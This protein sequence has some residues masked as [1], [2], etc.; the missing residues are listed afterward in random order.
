MYGYHL[1]I[2][3]M[4]GLL[5]RQSSITKHYHGNTKARRQSI[6]VEKPTGI[7]RVRKCRS[8]AGT[9]GRNL[10]RSALHSGEK[11]VNALEKSIANSS[12]ST[13]RGYASTALY[14]GGVTTT[15]DKPTRYSVMMAFREAFRGRNIVRS[16]FGKIPR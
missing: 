5:A 13:S 14:M 15:K 3:D 12:S 2:N 4:L 11:Q 16:R 10:Y 1:D 7:G 8:V 6:R 9:G